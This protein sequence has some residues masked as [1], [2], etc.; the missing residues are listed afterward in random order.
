MKYYLSVLLR[1]FLLLLVIYTVLR[2]IFGCMYLAGDWNLTTLSKELALGILI[3]F[4]SLIY[5]NFLFL[6][7]YLFLLPLI[8]FRFRKTIVLILLLLINLPFIAL[9]L[10]D[11][12]YYQYN[13]RRSTIDIIYALPGSVSS[14]GGLLSDY[15]WLL[16]LFIVFSW[17]LV[18]TVKKIIS[19]LD[20]IATVKW[21][22]H[23]PV[24]IVLIFLFILGA[25]GINN[26][27]LSPSTPLLYFDP[28]RQ[29]FISNSTQNFVFSVLQT[30]SRL[31]TIDYFSESRMKEIFSLKKI[32]DQ[33]APFNRKNVVLFIL[34]S[35]SELNFMPG[36]LKASMPFLDS[37]RA[38]GIVATNTFQNGHESVKGALSILAS[39]PPFLDEPL[40]VSNYNNIQMDGIGKLLSREGYSTNFFLGAEYDHFNFAKLCKMVGIENYYSKEDLP[41]RNKAFDDHTWG[42]FD[43]YFFDFFAK[44]TD[45]IEKPFFNVLY[46]IS[47]HPPFNIPSHRENQFNNTDPQL[48]ALSYVDFCFQ[49]LFSNIS[50]KDWYQNTL[51]FF[52]ADHGL[53]QNPEQ[54][55]WYFKKNLHIPFFIYD[56]SA[57]RGQSVTAITQQLDLVPTILDKLN[58]DKPFNS[59][60]NSIL[61]E[62]MRF[63]LSK[64]NGIYQLLDASGASGFDMQSGEV[65]YYYNFEVDSTFSDNRKQ[66]VDLNT[67]NLIKAI[68]QQYHNSLVR[69]SF[70]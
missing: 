35:F 58:Y 44:V 36:R 49:E 20:K 61:R 30:R 1:I 55:Y 11:L 38:S 65:V 50:T 16:G 66:K 33:E 46:N 21:F 42:I 67:V 68:L 12:F 4:S 53:V 23:I 52:I 7:I 14:F 37:L 28:V 24:S 69:N 59:F 48:R 29:P 32:Y 3:D 19:P 25:R 10:I 57:R 26:R 15:W 18:K 13:S 34:E 56:P 9:N 45:T 62:G 63:S 17:I 39:I 54:N 47:S 8:P 41:I 22:I 43:E 31:D 70:E 6:L 40:F 60:G 5:I 51:F 2:L 27:P 64:A